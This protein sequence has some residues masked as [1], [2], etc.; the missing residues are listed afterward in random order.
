MEDPA[1]VAGAQAELPSAETK[2]AI[3]RWCKNTIKLGG[4]RKQRSEARKQH[5]ERQKQGKEAVG[6]HMAQEHAQGARLVVDVGEDVKPVYVTYAPGVV[7]YRAPNKKIV[8]QA[9][10]GATVDAA[11]QSR[12]EMVQEIQRAVTERCQR[13]ADALSLAVSKKRGVEF[14]PSAS[15]VLKEQCALWS[16]ARSAALSQ[17]SEEE[18]QQMGDLRDSIKADT[19]AV[20]CYVK[21]QPGGIVLNVRCDGSEAPVPFLLSSRRKGVRRKH[22]DIT[23]CLSG[24]QPEGGDTEE[25]KTSVCTFILNQWEAG[26]TGEY[27]LSFKRK[28]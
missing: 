14:E 3:A 13:V 10:A 12:E 16:G 19:D 26:E 6:A 18:K 24:W 8:Q 11:S 20:L 25:V 17:N 22:E 4:V 7:S 27:T 5:T 23:E 15:T 1:S 9:V 21:E 2:A 28:K